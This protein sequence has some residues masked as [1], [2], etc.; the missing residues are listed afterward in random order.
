[1]PNWWSTRCSAPAS[2]ARWMGVARDTIEAAGRAAVPVV[3]I[4]I[5][6][7]VHGDTGAVLGAAASKRAYGHLS[8]GQAWAFPA[9]G[10]RLRRRAG[11]RRHRHPG[12]GGPPPPTCR[13]FAN[14]P[15]LWLGLLPRR[16]SAS[17]KYAHGHALVLGGGM[18]S[19]GAARM[20]ARAAL[21]AG[22]GLVTV[23]LPRRRACRLR[24]PADRGHGRAVRRPAGV[25]PSAR[26]PAAQRHSARPGRAGSARPC[27]SGCCAP[28]T[29]RKPASSMPMP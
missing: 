13:L 3:A 16:T 24:R 17:H 20:A 22:A 21:R 26:R 27:D 19:S 18:A 14:H 12:P 4:D 23:R 10:A 5:P 1:M 29:P 2:A 25:R 6:S 15:R 28:S 8:P 9:A 7:G 11:G